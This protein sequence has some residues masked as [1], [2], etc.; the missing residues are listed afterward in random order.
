MRE[1]GV[2]ER[3]FRHALS[4]F[5][6]LFHS[7]EVGDL[8]ETDGLSSAEIS[9]LLSETF[10]AAITAWAQASSR[11]CGPFSWGQP[12]VSSE[13]PRGAHAQ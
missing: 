12:H 8:H 7:R 11:Q 3:H 2:S 10:Y 9:A 13:V 4:L 6:E 5:N 1:I